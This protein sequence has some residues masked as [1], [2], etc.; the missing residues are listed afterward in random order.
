MRIRVMVMSG[1]DD[2][3]EISLQ[4]NQRF[5]G[6]L[7]SPDGFS[8]G[9]RETCDICI[10]YDTSVSRLHAHLQLR[11]G[12]LWLV[13]EDSRNGTFVGRTQVKE[14]MPLAVGE[15]FRVGNTWL[16]VQTLQE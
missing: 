7:E 16:R 14:A 13:D 12:E 4:V 11:D 5:D 2:G 6:Q 8:I 15:L 9:R 3:R 1:P 10:P